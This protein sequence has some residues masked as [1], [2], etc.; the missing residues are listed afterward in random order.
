VNN[1]TDPAEP[2]ATVST[3]PAATVS[4]E[5][6]ATVNTEPA[7]TVNTEPAATGS[8]EPAATGSTEPAAT[9]NTEPAQPVPSAVPALPPRRVGLVATLAIVVLALDQITK[10]LVVANV[11]PGEP[12]RILGGAV[13]LTLFRNAG[14]AFSTG[15]GLTWVLALVATAV[16]VWIIRT[17]SKLRSTPWAIALGLVL[18]G[19]VGNLCDRFF[20]SPGFLRG[21]VVDFI[22]L[23]EPD[24]GHFAIF[25]VADSGITLGGVALVITALLGID[26]DGSRARN[27]KEEAQRG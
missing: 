21:H 17:A 16:V 8:T 9:G 25:N 2:A 7:A 12:Q 18:G 3:E 6:A 26:M 22:S 20:R 15:T 10:L 11:T 4:T 24:G 13:Y 27:K 5:P 14:A 1:P 23:F 19:A